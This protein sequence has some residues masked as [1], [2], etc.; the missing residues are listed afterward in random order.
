MELI[1]KVYNKKGQK[2]GE[3]LD[4]EADEEI[5]GEQ[6]SAAE[7]AQAQ[8]VEPAGPLQPLFTEQ[9]NFDHKF[10]VYLDTEDEPFN[11]SRDLF[12]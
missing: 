9:A 1:A 7:P 11:Y 2:R 10:D 8:S 3:E 6:V 4:S 12:D 5:D